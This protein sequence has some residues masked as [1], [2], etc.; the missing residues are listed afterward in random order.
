MLAHP[1]N[2]E[3]LCCFQGPVAYA[4]RQR[5][6]ALRAKIQA[7]GSLREI[8]YPCCGDYGDYL[9]GFFLILSYPGNLRFHPGNSAVLRRVRVGSDAWISGRAKPPAAGIAGRN[10]T[11]LTLIPFLRIPRHCSCRGGVLHSAFFMDERRI[12]KDGLA[13]NFFGETY[14]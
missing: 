11:F 10:L 3:S 5:S 7:T 4:H 6:A 9:R 13:P 12:S 1:K 14:R 8:P 2:I